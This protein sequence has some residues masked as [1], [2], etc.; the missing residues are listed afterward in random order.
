MNTR[1]E[2]VMEVYNLLRLEGR[3]KMARDMA[4]LLECA[5]PTLSKAMKGD[6]SYTTDRFMKRVAALDARFSQTYLLTGEGSLIA[7][8][9]MNDEPSCDHAG[10][11]T[12]RF[13]DELSAQCRLTE[14]S[15]QQIDRLLGII[16]TMQDGAKGEKK[17]SAAG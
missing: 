12:A 1:A 7:E 15:Q 2:R 6:Q 9:A 16:E 10:M 13:L 4:G 11:D 5:E 17:V 8:N 14:K 3:V